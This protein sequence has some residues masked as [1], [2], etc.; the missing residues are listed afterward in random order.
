MHQ[1]E[2]EEEPCAVSP[3][4]ELIVLSEIQ[5]DFSAITVRHEPHQP[6]KANF[7]T[8]S[9]GGQTRRF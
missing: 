7:P 4:D 3:T 6:K 2:I 8:T 1:I 9:S 5:S